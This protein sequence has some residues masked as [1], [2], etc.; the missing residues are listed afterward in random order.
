MSEEEGTAKWCNDEKGYGFI[1]THEGGEDL[2]VHH[3]GLLG[4]GFKS[5]D[6]GKKVSYEM[7]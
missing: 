3:S 2:F 7:A 4:E 1:R 6:E 5:L